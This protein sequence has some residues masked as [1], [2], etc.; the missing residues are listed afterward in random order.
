VK[1]RDDSAPL[2]LRE[3]S[4]SAPNSRAEADAEICEPLPKVAAQTPAWQSPKSLIGDEVPTVRRWVRR[5]G[6]ILDLD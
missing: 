3:P 5:P 6:G 2:T 1:C 4:T